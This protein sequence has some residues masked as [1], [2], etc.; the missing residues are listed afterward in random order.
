MSFPLVLCT[1]MMR[2]GSTW[3][4]NVCRLIG[5]IVAGR[6]K[7]PMW[8]G[9]RL[10]AEADAF[11]DQALPNPPGPTILKIHK[12]TPRGLEIL[13]RN[14][15]KAVCTFRDP[16]DCVASMITFANASFDVALQTIAQAL[17]N[18]N[19]TASPNTLFIRYEDMIQNRLAHIRA[20]AQHLGVFVDQ[21]LCEKIDSLTSIERSREVCRSLKDRPEDTV[22]R[23]MNDHRVDPETWL[24]DN[25]IQ[26]GRH[27]RWKEEM[28]ADQV[29]ILNE[30]YGP[31]LQRL[32]YGD[33]A[34]KIAV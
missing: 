28:S 25:H 32:G 26:N 29:R 10:A 27:G 17:D 1:G 8:S 33:S 14:Q 19:G 34:R 11:F 20:I 15:A 21:S 18:L 7:K 2:S 22:L 24:H 5:K 30:T 3:S 31:W 23:A 4:F 12:L 9:Y 13:N 6:E 16:R